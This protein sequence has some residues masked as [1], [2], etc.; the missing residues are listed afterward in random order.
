M[1]P[2][3]EA[4]GF[5]QMGGC[6]PTGRR[7]PH[8]PG[9]ALRARHRTTE[10]I[11]TAR[12]GRNLISISTICRSTC[13]RGS[14]AGPRPFDTRLLIAEQ[15]ARGTRN[16]GGNGNPT[17]TIGHE[18]NGPRQR[19]P[20]RRGVQPVR[21]TLTFGGDLGSRASTRFIQRQSDHHAVSSPARIPDAT[22]T[23]AG[24][25]TAFDAVPIARRSERPA[26]AGAAGPRPPTVRSSEVRHS[27][28]RRPV[29]G[30]RSARQP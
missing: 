11:P 4:T 15:P 26:P 1:V 27:A 20:G 21:Q 13:S 14:G 10:A 23:R 18:Q 12:Q 28:R 3:C 9:G 16:Q 24:P 19:V 17:A 29:G 5:W 30:G 7:S 6:P 22:A 25:Q 2:G 8:G